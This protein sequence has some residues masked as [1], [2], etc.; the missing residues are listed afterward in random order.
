MIPGD[1][2]QTMVGMVTRKVGYWI[3]L[4]SMA[5]LLVAAILNNNEGAGKLQSAS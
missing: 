5:A 3:W 1:K 2:T 4:Y